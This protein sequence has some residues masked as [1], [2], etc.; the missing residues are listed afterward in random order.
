[1]Y[2]E[3]ATRQEGVSAPGTVVQEMTDERS[4]EE[5]YRLEHPRV[6]AT[7]LLVTGDLALAADCADEAFARALQ[8][9]RRVSAMRSP[10]GWVFR[11]ARN[12]S[13]RALRRASL[14]RRL[15]LR[16]PRAAEVPAPAGE[17]WAL[18][19]CLPR[20]QREIVALRHV[21]DMR[22]AEVAEA[23]GL[24][25]STVSPRAPQRR[26]W[27]SATA[28]AG[29]ALWLAPAARSSWWRASPRRGW[30]LPA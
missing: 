7:M 15:L 3:R 8:H 27:Q 12:C 20:R 6:V 11:V 4:F 21:A 1:M 29:A 10:A 16:T 23:L 9:W 25:R 18:V 19:G 14:E 13:R 30:P 5:W 2:A 24:S 26:D 17:M 28:G 22:E